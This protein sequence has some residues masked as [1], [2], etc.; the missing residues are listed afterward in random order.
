MTTLRAAKLMALVVCVGTSVAWASPEEYKVDPVHSSVWFRI[1]HLGVSYCYG[2]FNEPM[3]SFVWDEQNPEASKFTVKVAVEKIDTDNEKR[4][5]HLR[6]VDFF[7]AAKHP[8]ITFTS[9]AIKPQGDNKFEVTGDLTLHG[10]TKSITVVLEHVGGGKD[11]WGGFR[12]GFET[13]F[14][15]KR[16]DFGMNYMQGPLGDEVTL[17]VGIEGVRASD[18]QE[19]TAR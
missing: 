12:R 11:P 17:K 4:D 18:N 9:T 19:Q 7:D 3:G 10:V 13:K 16:S 14:T 2:R 5:Q 8:E 1:K 15:I 6:G